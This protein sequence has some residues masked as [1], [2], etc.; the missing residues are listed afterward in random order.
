MDCTSE[1]RRRED[2]D[3]SIEDLSAGLRPNVGL[4]VRYNG[5]LAHSR[6]QALSDTDHK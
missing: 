3:I 2:V 5:R 4:I 6:R 1:T